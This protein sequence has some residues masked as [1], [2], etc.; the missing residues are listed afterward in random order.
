MIKKKVILPLTIYLYQLK[1]RKPNKVNTVVDYLGIYKGIKN[2]SDLITRST[3][4]TWCPGLTFSLDLK[5]AKHITKYNVYVTPLR[6]DLDKL[7]SHI[8][9]TINLMLQDL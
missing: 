3:L 2:N 1:I 9:D 5:F 4:I 6:K 7:K 8:T